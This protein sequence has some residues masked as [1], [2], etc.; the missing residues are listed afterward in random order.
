[1][2]K[3]RLETDL[4]VVTHMPFTL[5]PSPFKKSHYEKVFKLQL[6]INELVHRLAT[7]KETL[8]IA[9]EGYADL[10]GFF[11]ILNYSGGNLTFF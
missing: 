5:Y 2:P 6:H 10:T 1:V 9:F 8:E 3:T 7:S 4:M 11:I